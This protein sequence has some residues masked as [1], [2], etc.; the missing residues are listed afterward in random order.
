MSGRFHAQRRPVEE[1]KLQQMLFTWDP[2]DLC[3]IFRSWHI[4]S[5][6]SLILSLVAV[7]ILTAGYELVREVS[8]RYERAADRANERESEQP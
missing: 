4:R 8:R 1:L 3:I 7:A 6:G 2:T 5:T